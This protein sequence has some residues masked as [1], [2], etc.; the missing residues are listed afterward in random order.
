[1][2]AS[3]PVRTLADIRL[4]NPCHD[5]AQHVSEDWTGTALDVLQAESISAEERI[6]VVTGPGWIDDKTLRT[7]AVWCARSLLDK[8][9]SP[10]PRCV[11][12]LQTAAT[13]ETESRSTITTVARNA[14]AATK[15]AEGKYSMALI[16]QVEM[17][18]AQACAYAIH[19]KASTA[20]RGAGLAVNGVR[21]ISR[22]KQVEKLLDLLRGVYLTE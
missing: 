2:T 19:P 22:E 4:Q 17:A 20:A 5:P 15:E 7:F 3:L 1:M 9:K 14:L 10:D 8:V 11:A 12:A 21:V 13:Y 6:W 16:S 18:A